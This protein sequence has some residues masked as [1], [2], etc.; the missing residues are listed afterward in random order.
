MFPATGG[1]ITRIDTVSDSQGGSATMTVYVAISRARKGATIYT[2]SR[3]DLTEALG[4]RDGARV[5]AM[6]EA[7]KQGVGSRDV[8]PG[9]Y[10]PILL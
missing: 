5:G 3:A 2:D 1:P 8:R 10:L 4:L 6:D 9:A 7:I